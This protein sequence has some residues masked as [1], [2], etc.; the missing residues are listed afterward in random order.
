MFFYYLFYLIFFLVYERCIELLLL[1]SL[2]ALVLHDVF[3]QP[4]DAGIDKKYPTGATDHVNQ[5]TNQINTR[6]TDYVTFP[7]THTA[8]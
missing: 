8:S 6:T 5:M 3:S 2:H 4:V 1:F 7:P